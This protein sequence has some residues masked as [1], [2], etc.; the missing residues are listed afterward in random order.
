MKAIAEVLL[1]LGWLAGVV[2]ASGFWSTAAA[3][4]IPFYAWYL[5]MERAMQLAGWISA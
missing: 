4:C 3:V 1:A 5:V 2:L